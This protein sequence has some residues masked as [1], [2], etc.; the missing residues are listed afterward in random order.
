[1]KDKKV[2]VSSFEIDHTKMKAPQVRLADEYKFGNIKIAKYDLRFT[3]P[4]TKYLSAKALHTLEHLLAGFIREELDSSKTKV[5]D[6]SPMGCKTGFY[7]TVVGAYSNAVIKKG[8]INAL[9]K[10]QK[11]KNIPAKTDKECGN[12][13]LHSLLEAKK[14]A[15]E[16]IKKIK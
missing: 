8:L 3:K 2:L 14:I 9:G 10:V 4:N 16:F 5:I 6:L 1:M 7:L 11:A 15:K 12:Y 13:K